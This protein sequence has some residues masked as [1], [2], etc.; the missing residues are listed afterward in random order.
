MSDDYICLTC[1]STLTVEE[2]REVNAVYDVEARVFHCG[3]F[4]N[5]V[6]P[7]KIITL[8][9]ACSIIEQTQPEEEYEEVD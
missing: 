2:L 3:C 7:G 6:E 9:T 1:R 5:D 4:P 8:E